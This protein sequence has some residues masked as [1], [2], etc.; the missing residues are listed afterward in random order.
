MRITTL[1]F[2]SD[3]WHLLEREAR[4]AG[5][6]VSQFIREAALARAVAASAHRREDPFEALAAGSAAAARRKA[7]EKDAGT[8]TADRSRTGLQTR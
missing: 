5:L 1:R 4:I 8:K 3:L 6:S 2:G 7:N